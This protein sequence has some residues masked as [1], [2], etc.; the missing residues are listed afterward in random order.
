[1]RVLA[2]GIASLALAGCASNEEDSSLEPHRYVASFYP[3]AWA[4]EHVTSE[5]SADVVNLT[6]PGV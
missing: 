6:T 3:L 4:S 2:I 1:M 5:S